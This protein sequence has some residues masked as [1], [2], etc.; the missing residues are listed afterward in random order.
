MPLS[1][2]DCTVKV[3]HIKLVDDGQREGE[4]GNTLENEVNV[5]DLRQ[6]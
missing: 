1:R 2:V 4:R 6:V 3:K 5:E